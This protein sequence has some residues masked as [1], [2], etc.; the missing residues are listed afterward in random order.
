[1][2]FNP[3]S[4]RHMHFSAFLQ[5]IISNHEWSKRIISSL[6]CGGGHCSIEILRFDISIYL[7]G[8]SAY[9][10]DNNLFI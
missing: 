10:V 2:K 4:Y 5:L 1:M 3:Y 9:L 7:V 6:Q 8:S